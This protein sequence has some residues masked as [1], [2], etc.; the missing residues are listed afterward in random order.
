MGRMMAAL[1]LA[2]CLAGCAAPSGEEPVSAPAAQTER[3]SSSM[4][5]SSAR[6]LP[7]AEVLA[8]YERAQRVYEIGRA[9]V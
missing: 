3:M 9:H 8:A 4:V 5:E 6:P 7:E 2:F 1:L